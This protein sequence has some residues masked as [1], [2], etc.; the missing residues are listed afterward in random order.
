[1]IRSFVFQKKPP[2]EECHASTIAELR[3]GSL[4]AAWF[5]GDEEG[6]PST[7][8]W[9]SRYEK[10]E[11]TYPFLLAEEPVACWNPVLFAWPDGTLW[12]FYKVG[13]TVSSWTGAYK[14]SEDDGRS[15]SDARY[16]PAG[17]L[18]AIKNKPILSS[19]GELIC[20]TSAESY[21]AWTCWAEIVSEGGKDWK[22]YGPIEVPGKPY[23]VIQ[24]TLWELEPGH[25][26]FLMRSTQRIG[27]VCCAD[28]TDGGRTW[29]DA[30]PISLPNPNSGIDAIKLSDGRIVLIYN[31]TLRSDPHDGRYR[32]HMNISEDGGDTWGEPTL[33]EDEGIEYSY[34]AVI[35]TSD[36]KIH[37]TYTWN[38]KNIQ[39]LI[40][41]KGE[42]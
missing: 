7:D 25:V 33:L 18:G 31:H 22:R 2:F 8:I 19:S 17:L 30:R 39:H 40:F 10:G 41:D 29:T 37:V 36:G 13:K 24:P 23:G 15:W 21:N 11:W 35:E 20:G 9:G 4:L 3:D 28:S 42:I 1:M 6:D 27:A 14:V 12:L 26:R 38:R 32:I 16:L 34:P 5:G